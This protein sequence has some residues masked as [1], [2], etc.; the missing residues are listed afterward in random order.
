MPP[1]G[2]GAPTRSVP[3][4]PSGR[5]RLDD[6]D[7][8]GRRR[9]RLP[10]G[11]PRGRD[12]PARR[13]GGRGDRRRTTL[14]RRMCL[15][16]AARPARR[17]VGAGG[18]GAQVGRARGRR[19]PRRTPRR[20]MARPVPRGRSLG[21]ARERFRER[22]GD[23]RR[24]LGAAGRGGR[25]RRR[26]R[27]DQHALVDRIRRVVGEIENVEVV[28]D[29]ERPA[30]P[31]G[32]VLLPLRQRRGAGERARSARVRRGQRIGVHG[33]VAGAQ[34]RAGGHGRAH[35]RQ[36][37]GLGRPRDRPRTTSSGFLEL[38]PGAVERLR[39]RL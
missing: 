20:A 13:R 30:A 19:G 1:P 7:V 23:P 6:L 2:R 18:V 26:E 17:M 12:R 34:P 10:V 9:R 28:G 3:V 39:A 36:R 37:P 14:R 38:L 29:P 8:D 25:A 16:R 33:L 35:P 5:L 32:H 11:Q 22:A 21:R 15:G 4:D 24:G 27:A 31:P